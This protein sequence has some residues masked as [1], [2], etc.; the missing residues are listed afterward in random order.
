MGYADNFAD[1]GPV[2]DDVQYRRHNPFH[3]MGHKIY[4][5]PGETVWRNGTT[6]EVIEIARGRPKDLPCA[7]CGEKRTS[8]GHDP[9]IANLPGVTNACCGHGLIQGYVQF[10]SGKVI[11]GDFDHI[12]L[13][14]M[15]DGLGWI[16][17]KALPPT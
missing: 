15:P 5:R 1:C 3:D 11:R 17:G 9:C 10:S 16:V 6:D 13:I 12:R 14:P 2:E 7:S 8:E 4:Q